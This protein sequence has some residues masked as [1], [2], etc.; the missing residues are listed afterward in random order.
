MTDARMT[1]ANARVAHPSV[2][3][4]FPDL[5]VVDGTEVA[6]VRPTEMLRQSPNGP[7]VSEVLFGE[8]LTALEDRDGW[9][10]VIHGRDGYVGYLPSPAL[11]PAFEPTHFVAVRSSHVYSQDNFKSAPISPQSFGARFRVIS[12]TARFFETEHGFLPKPHL[13]PLSRPFRDPVTVAQMFFGTP[14]LWAGC[15]GFGIDCSGL[16]QQAARAAGVACPRDS[17]QQEAALGSPLAPD[18][19]TMRGDL[20]FW[21]GHVAVAV[22]DTTL[23]HANAHHMAV[24]YE[25]ISV[26]IARIEGQGEGPVTSR[27]RLQD[28]GASS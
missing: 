8:T 27:R 11:G 24:A 23:I 6:L 12:E 26:A 2:A 14:Y 20:Y 5:T 13:R 28:F 25:P 21:K 22:D 9:S 1:P 16:V 10:F 7:A 19:P 18:A 3:S 4:D 17:D 15:S